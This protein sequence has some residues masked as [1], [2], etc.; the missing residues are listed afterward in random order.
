MEGWTASVF[1]LFSFCVRGCWI[2]GDRNFPF[3]WHCGGSTSLFSC[4][5]VEER[6]GATVNF[7]SHLNVVWMMYD[8][9][10]FF[11]AFFFRPSQCAIDWSFPSCS[12]SLNLPL[13]SFPPHHS[14]FFFLYWTIYQSTWWGLMRIFVGT[15]RSE[16]VSSSQKLLIH[17]NRPG[18]TRTKLYF[19]ESIMM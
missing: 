9:F 7:D 11:N 1:F 16:L 6:K 13:F 8:F 12:V 5:C 18:R 19:K 17:Q 3:S 10:R 14:S 2:W 4:L 15:K